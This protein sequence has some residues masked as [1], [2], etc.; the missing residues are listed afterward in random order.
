MLQK[1]TQYSYQLKSLNPS[2]FNKV[3]N[4]NTQNS[5]QKIAHLVLFDMLGLMKM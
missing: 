1:N 5:K 4:I 2:I 3:R